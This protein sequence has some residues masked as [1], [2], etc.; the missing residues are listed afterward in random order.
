MLPSAQALCAQAFRETRAVH[1]QEACC[2]A[3]ERSQKRWG[4]WGGWVGWQGQV[5]RAK[6]K[7]EWTREMK[8][9]SHIIGLTKERGK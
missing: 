1:S 5:Q 4:H 6:L 7:D 9:I 8:P 3:G 2:E